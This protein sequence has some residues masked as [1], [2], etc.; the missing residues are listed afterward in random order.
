MLKTDERI[1]K[2]AKKYS[3]PSDVVTL[4]SESFG[5]ERCENILASLKKPP[6]FY[7]LRVNMLAT[8]RDKVIEALGELGVEAF[9]HP[10]IEEAVGIPVKGPFEV[11]A[12]EKTVVADKLAC[13]S[14]M[15]GA[16]LYAPG[17]ITAKGVKRG[18]KVS[19]MDKY[20]HLVAI[21]TALMDAWEMHT[22][23]SGLAVK[24][25]HSI[26]KIPS[27]RGTNIYEDGWVYEQSLPAIITSRILDPK[28]GSIVVDMC[29]APGGKA[30]HIAQLMKGEGL[31]LA[32]DRSKSRIKKL[33]EHM[34]RMKLKNI[35][36]L[37]GDSRFI[38]LEY[39][40]LRADAVLVDPPCSDLGLRPKLYEEKKAS[41][42]KATAEYQRQF[43]RAAVRILKPGG[44]LVY[45]T[46]TIT[47]EE[48]EKNVEFC[49]KELGLE[50]E[51]QPLYLGDRGIG[52]FR[53]ANLTQ[54]F[55]PDIHETPGFFIAKLR[56]P[57][58]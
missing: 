53:E 21:G 29:A 30:T 34:K 58:H 37:S 20:G 38:H 24:I 42:I 57:D 2:L 33:E 48:N 47:L 54:R 40:K 8:D 46:C 4:L 11:E 17:V 32:F 26:Y 6:P 55:F 18:D 27:I 1:L 35:V 12:C 23:K 22:L 3:F 50:V 51:E 9:P 25:T 28:P 14:V 49:V 36:V 45:S 16:D 31:V 10:Q 19:V 41:M 52:T 7:Y 43:L 5:F 15:V 56:K 13:E 39:P 44:I